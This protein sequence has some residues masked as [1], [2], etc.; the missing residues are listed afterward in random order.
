MLATNSLGKREQAYTTKPA[1]GQ[2][3]SH[4]K[5]GTVHGVHRS[6][7]TLVVTDKLGHTYL[8]F[9]TNV[10]LEKFWTYPQTYR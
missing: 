1:H 3:I 10:A 6:V 7:L 8:I 4:R 9:Q 2:Y 5:R